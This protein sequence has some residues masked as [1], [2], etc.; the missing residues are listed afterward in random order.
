MIGFSLFGDSA[1]RLWKLTAA[2]IAILLL[3]SGPTLVSVALTNTGMLTLR[4]GLMAQDDFVPRAYHLYNTLPDS[5]AIRQA[6]GHLYQAVALDKSCLPARWALGRAALAVGEAEV[7][8]DAMRPLIAHAERNPLLYANALTAL[9]RGGEPEGV[10]ALYEAAPPPQPNQAVSDTVALAYLDQER[11]RGGEG[12]TR[13]GWEKVLELRSGDLYANYH[14]W[15]QAQEAGDVR[16]AA[17]YSETLTYFPLEAVDPT[18]ERLVRYAAQ[19]IPKLLE[20]R[21]WDRDKTLNVVTYLVW[22]HNTTAG[23]VHLLED[24]IARYPA[25]PDW[26]FY[27]AELYHRRGNLDQADTAYKQ[28]VEMDAQYTQAYLRLGMLAEER[29]RQG[30]GGTRRQNVAEAAAWYNHYHA[31]APDDLLGLKRLTETCAALEEAH[32]EDESCIAAAQRV[33]RH[34]QLAM[35]DSSSET[36]AQT[37]TPAAVLQEALASH[38]DDR[39]IVAEL[40]EVPVEEVK[41]GPNLVGDGG[42]ELQ[43]RS[44]TA[45]WQWSSMFNRDP[46]SP[47]AFLG[48]PDKLDA[49]EE[50]QSARIDGLWVQEVE[51]RSP[52]RA[53]FWHNS[54]IAPMASTPYVVSFYYSTDGIAR[55]QGAAIWLS[56][57]DDVF[58]RS[59]LWLTNTDGEWGHFVAV[60]WNRSSGESAVR[61]L[62]RSFAPGRFKIDNVQIRLVELSEKI[63]ALEKGTRTWEAH[64]GM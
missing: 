23:V 12:E 38:T 61:P 56:D 40:L 17:A 57:D 20:E 2:T 13:R 25:Q 42:F 60:T 7:A 8:A 34:T 4:D 31:G 54:E 33:S 26:P 21:V 49:F 36:A 14:L 29:G 50:R 37:E 52:A 3:L 45:M 53:G 39:R 24:L 32:V 10:L 1:E 43:R 11:G 15:K 16:A 55:K 9:S 59:N 51:N 22:Q 18:D 63:G 6:M 47:A 46:F 27:L 62:I 5:L 30:E 48:G 64:K 44:W 19:V 28:V 35:R 58:W 41:L